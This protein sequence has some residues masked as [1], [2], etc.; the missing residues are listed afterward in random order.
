MESDLAGA[1]SD[2]YIF[3]GGKRIARRQTAS[4]TLHYYF[5]DHLGSSRVVTSATG[6]ILDDSD[7][8]PFGGERPVTSSTDNPYLFTGKERDTE[9]GLDFF[10]ARYYSPA[11]GRF[12]Q[13]D[14][15]FADQ[16]QEDSQ[17]WNL[18]TYV[19]NNPLIHVDP[20]GRGM[21]GVI[22]KWV[23]KVEGARQT[24]DTAKKNAATVVDSKK[25]LADR[26]EAGGKI[27][28]EVVL[29]FSVQ[30]A[31]DLGKL[32]G[33][34]LAKL[35]DAG[36]FTALVTGLIAGGAYTLRDPETEEV[37]RSGRTNDLDRRRGE[38]ARGKETKGLDFQV[39]NRTNSPNARRGLEQ[40]LHDKHQPPLDK[41]N[42]IAP[43][44][45]KKGTYIEAA[46]KFLRRLIK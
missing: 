35:D 27:L 32:G 8:Y 40:M 33:E 46:L 37:Q 44:N 14:E 45:P 6:T 5:S 34:G 36:G 13:T 11:Q 21:I 43:T 28:S 4:G 24:V 26:V 22:I 3:F 19:R 29:P 12:L 42:P 41:I 31:E 16:E 15:P 18:Y 20:T 30:D 39:E 38:H 23:F 2:E 10:I 9:S 1:V 7:F 17:S 25:P